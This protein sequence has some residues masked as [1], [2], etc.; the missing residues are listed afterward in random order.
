MQF[1]LYKMIEISGFNHQRMIVVVITPDTNWFSA[2]YFGA[3][4]F[5]LFKRIEAEAKRGLPL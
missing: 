5:T 1:E 4:H 2:I 3:T